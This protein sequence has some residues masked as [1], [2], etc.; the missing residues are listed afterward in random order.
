MGTYFIVRCF[1]KAVK[2]KN[3]TEYEYGPYLELSEAIEMMINHLAPISLTR[4]KR[5]KLIFKAEID[6]VI[7]TGLGLWEP[8]RKCI[9]EMER[10]I[11]NE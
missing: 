8:L 5:G 9:E 11:D 7:M 10:K 3:W 4:H 1:I 6:E 2:E